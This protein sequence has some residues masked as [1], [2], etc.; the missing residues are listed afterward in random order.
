MS[1]SQI[2]KLKSKIHHCIRKAERFDFNFDR[3]TINFDSVESTLEDPHYKYNTKS[4]IV[5]ILKIQTHNPLPFFF[6]FEVTLP[7]SHL[8]PNY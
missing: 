8:K 6:L 7:L 5:S 2:H 3:F 1:Q 4:Q